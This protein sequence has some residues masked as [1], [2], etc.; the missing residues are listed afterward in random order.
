[1]NVGEWLKVNQQTLEAAGV[2][3]ARLD[4]TVLLEDAL[5]M[6]RV[7]LLAHLD[8]EI[9]KD[10]QNL[11]K[12]LVERRMKH[13]PL[14]YIRGKSEFYGREFIVNDSVLVPRPESEA[15]IE[16]LL[17]YYRE[18]SRLRG[19]D[20][21]GVGLRV[22]DIGTGSGALGITAQL[23]LPGATVELL[24]ID[25]KA[26]ATAKMNVINFTSGNK[27]IKSDLLYDSSTNYHVLLCNLPYV[28]DD[29]EIN[30]AAR[31]EP[32]IALFA[33]A[34]GLAVYRRL[35]EQLKRLEYLPLLILTEA[36][37]AQHSALQQLATKS[38]YALTTSEGY[39]QAFEPDM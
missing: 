37:P 6:D 16:V 8:L 35:F 7:R 29:Y 10:T 14:A 13:E 1:M 34:D 28:P 26:L 31:H 18:D 15:M 5:G 24:D 23:E 11:L 39:I 22:A 25:E 17:R 2:L 33:G 32:T 9:D 27:V 12:A 20:E 3:T 21:R 19:N 38:G 36:M 30:E 4:V